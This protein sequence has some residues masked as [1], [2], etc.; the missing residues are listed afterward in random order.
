MRPRIRRP[1]YQRVSTDLTAGWNHK[2]NK[3][4]AVTQRIAERTA[5]SAPHSAVLHAV[6]THILPPLAPLLQAHPEPRPYLANSR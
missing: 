4:S 5:S 2:R 6:R 3:S 1:R